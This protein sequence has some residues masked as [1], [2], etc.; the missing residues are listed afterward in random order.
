MKMIGWRKLGLGIGIILLA[1]GFIYFK[2]Q[3][4]G[5]G[6]MM[7][8][9]VPDIPTNV[10]DIILGVFF[11]FVGGNVATHFAKAKGNGDK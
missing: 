5:V 1:Y 11:A 3:V 4:V 9:Q 10:R 7:T 2:T 8:I 6:A